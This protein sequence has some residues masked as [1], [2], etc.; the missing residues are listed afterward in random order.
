MKPA[1]H[2]A[3]TSEAASKGAAH[4]FDHNISRWHDYHQ[5]Q[6]GAR[7]L[8]PPN[9]TFC[10]LCVYRLEWGTARMS[11]FHSLNVIIGRQQE[12]SGVSS[13]LLVAQLLK[14]RIL[15]IKPRLWLHLWKSLLRR[16]AA[17]QF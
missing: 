7:L 13:A 12:L 15:V 4:T 8:L 1:A 5:K 17:F 6:K 3:A 10:W 9:A 11:V 14:V 16:R 2:H